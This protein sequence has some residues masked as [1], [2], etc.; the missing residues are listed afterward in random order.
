MLYN[1]RGYNKVSA[2][3]GG[4]KLLHYLLINI[5]RAPL[6]L[7]IFIRTREQYILLAEYFLT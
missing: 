6:L 2:R 4:G 7:I 5:S 3:I 1:N